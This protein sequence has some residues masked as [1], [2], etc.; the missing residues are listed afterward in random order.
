MSMWEGKKK[1]R[2]CLFA[3]GNT[4]KN[5]YMVLFLIIS[6]NVNVATVL[7]HGGVQP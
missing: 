7:I 4:N 6:E 3:R 5:K 1:K 2:D